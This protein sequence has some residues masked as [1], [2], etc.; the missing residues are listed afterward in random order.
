MAR[1]SGGRT[2]D[3]PPE[4]FAHD[5]L[6]R[7]RG[8]SPMAV[9]EVVCGRDLDARARLVEDGTGVNDEPRYGY[10]RSGSQVVVINAEWRIQLCP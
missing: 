2:L 5:A 8:G 1:S 3:G 10:L 7:A 4:W 6:E 9:R